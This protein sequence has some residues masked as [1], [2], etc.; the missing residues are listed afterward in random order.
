M[1]HRLKTP[2]TCQHCG[3]A[4]RPVHRESKYCSMACRNLESN[5]VGNHNWHG[6]VTMQ[7]GYVF[8][9]MGKGVRKREHI[10]IVERALGY[11]LP[12]K[13]CVHHWDEDRSNNTPSNLVVCQDHAYHMLLHA[14]A[15]R[16]RDTGSF[17][18]KRCCVCKEVKPLGAF[19]NRQSN[20][21]GRYNS[22]RVCTQNAEK[23]R[24]S[25]STTG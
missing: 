11:P 25:N 7:H 14:R 5:G 24:R 6:G 15:N 18:L 17:D 22:C 20:W 4:F 2:V 12:D 10:L 1:T 3:I 21:D 9:T 13:A 23:T 19:G 16:L 8:R